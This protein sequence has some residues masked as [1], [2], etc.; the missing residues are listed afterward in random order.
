M[1]LY[2]HRKHKV[3]HKKKHKEVRKHREKDSTVFEL[4]DKPNFNLNL[5]GLLPKNSTEQK[6]EEKSPCILPDSG[7]GD[8]IKQQCL[9]QKLSIS[10]KRLNT[11]AYERCDNTSTEASSVGG[12]GDEV[13]NGVEN[14][15]GAILGTTNYSPNSGQSLV[16]RLSA[17]PVTDSAKRMDVGDV[18]WGKVHGFPWWPG[19]VRPNTFD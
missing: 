3:K 14:E 2:H 10:L 12:S 7:S 8:L 15:S 13:S 1:F 4:V 16:M 9:K 5:T 11:N 18:V 6:S 17:T 19:K